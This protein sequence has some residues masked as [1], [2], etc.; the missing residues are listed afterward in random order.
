MLKF[1]NSPLV[2]NAA[3]LLSA[4]IFAQ[5]LGLAVYPLL[6][7]LYAPAEFGNFSLFFSTAGILTLI[8]TAELQYALVLPQDEKKAWNLLQCAILVLGVTT[9][10]TLF[11]PLLALYVLVYGLWTLLNYWYIRRAQFGAISHYQIAQ[12][13]ASAA[14]K[15]GFGFAKISGGLIFGSVFAP[16]FSLI[17]NFFSFGKKN[18]GKLWKTP[19]KKAELIATIKEYKNFPCFN[20]PKSL[21]NNLGGNLPAILLAPA[22]GLQELGFFSMALTLAFH[23]IHIICSSI[24]QVLYQK[25]AACYNQN[26][27]ISKIFFR[28]LRGATAVGLLGVAVLYG[29][30]P[31]LCGWFLGQEWEIAGEYIRWLFPRIFLNLLIEPI[32]SLHD[33]LGKQKQSLFFE[34]LLFVCSIG[35]L[36]LGIFLKEIRFSI[37]GYSLGASLAL[38]AQLFW[39]IF[40]VKNYEKK[41]KI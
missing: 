38:L 15:S 22:F 13:V 14:I 33:V 23:P 18:V 37:I 35:G 32:C 19:F 39:Y 9:L 40:L 26:L 5:A 41:I 17:L 6:T 2:R 3:K 12:S 34:I 8:S 30:L 16:L 29:V 24:Y 36:S 28:Y 7:R 11:K 10:A 21:V 25:F 1:A 27:T 4:N 20:L 31:G